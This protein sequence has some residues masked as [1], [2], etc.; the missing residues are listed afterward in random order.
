VSMNSLAFA[1]LIATAATVQSGAASLAGQWTATYDGKTF[2]R[3]ELKPAGDEFTGGLSLGNIEVDNKGAVIRV[4]E[5][6]R[7][8]AP[9]FDVARRDALILF[10]R[11]DG[12]SVDR[13][14]LKPIDA[15]HAELRLLLSDADRRDL[16][17]IGVP[18]PKPITLTKAKRP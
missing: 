12:E 13:F 16:A 14:E 9:I 10:S 1:L 15:T 5:A 4:A 18:A 2:A 6:P 7:S 8:L 11:K 3:L 17:A